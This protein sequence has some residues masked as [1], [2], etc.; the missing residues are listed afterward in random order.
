MSFLT[1]NPNRYLVTIPSINGVVTSASGNVE[2]TSNVFAS[3]IDSNTNAASFNTIQSY[4]RGNPVTFTN[5]LNLS[6]TSILYNGTSLLTLNTLN[7]RL[8]TA[9]QINN[10]EVARLTPV[11]LGIGNKNP[12]AAL[13]VSGVTY[14]NG[15]LYVKGLITH[16]GN[17]AVVG[18]V[19]T[20]GNIETNG[21]ISVRCGS[22]YISSFGLPLNSTVGN[23]YADGDLFASG[24]K[25]PSD[26][27]L[28][29]NIIPYEL[30]RALPEPVEFIWKSNGQ[31]DIGVLASDVADI[32]PTCVHTNANGMRSV[33][34]PK[35]VVLCLAELKRLKDHVGRQD[36][37]IQELQEA[38]RQS[39]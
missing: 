32:E 14:L 30:H 21:N 29:A 15:T 31:R 10:L 34:Y 7:T 5:N 18:N 19:N 8:Y 17:L 36:Q 33:D 37:A 3:Y 26:P 9:F 39:P 12:G 4:T 38:M 23:L 13:D 27:A 2:G 25:Y 16:D 6:N 1:T 28:K 22:M 35:L 24:I 20:I 11:G